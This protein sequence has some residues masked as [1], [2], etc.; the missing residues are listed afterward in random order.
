M[1]NLSEERALNE[2]IPTKIFASSSSGDQRPT[3][4]PY[5]RNYSKEFIKIGFTC[6]LINQGF[7]NFLGHGPL[8]VNIFFLEPQSYV[9]SIFLSNLRGKMI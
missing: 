3:K 1:E 2:P 4:Q 9:E 7:P 5:K 8:F 6:I